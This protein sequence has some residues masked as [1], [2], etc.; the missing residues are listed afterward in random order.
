MNIL[1]IGDSCTDVFV[2]GVCNRLCPEGPVPVFN[3]IKQIENKGMA[4]NVLQNLKSLGVENVD[5]IT[6]SEDVKKSGKSDMDNSLFNL[7]I[8]SKF[9]IWLAL[10]YSL[11][12]SK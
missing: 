1:I 5:I 12:L 9:S 3:P 11:N 8:L 2:Y 6:N 10:S 4:G 7:F